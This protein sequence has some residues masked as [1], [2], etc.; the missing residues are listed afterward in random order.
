MKICGTCKLQKPFED[1]N[2]RNASPDG[3]ANICRI[4][5]SEYQKKYNFDNRDKLSKYRNEWRHQNR[6][7][8]K[9]YLKEYYKTNKK[10]LKE[11]Q[12]DYYKSN[13]EH[14][15]NLGKKYYREN[16][17]TISKWNKEYQKEKY[18]TTPIFSLR[19]KV[20]RRLW[21][22]F[23]NRIKNGNTRQMLGCSWEQL[24]EHLEKQFTPQMTWDNHG[25]FGWHI[26]H[27]IPLSSAKNE[28]EILK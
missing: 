20:R 8:T 6:E 10:V 1:F 15:N 16:K 9:N 22:F 28:E 7:Y 21:S 26:D 11:K 13:K 18:N 27:I 12:K 17:E 2:K 5:N 19:V 14:L 23:R 25:Q 4:C 3:Y 24:K